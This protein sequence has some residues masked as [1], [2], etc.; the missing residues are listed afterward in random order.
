MPSPSGPS[1]RRSSVGTA[2]RPPNSFRCAGRWCL[3]SPSPHGTAAIWG[4]VSQLVPPTCEPGMVGT[5]ERN[6]DFVEDMEKRRAAREERRRQERA[7][8]GRRPART[9]TPAHAPELWKTDTGSCTRCL[10][11][12]NRRSPIR[13]KPPLVP[14]PSGNGLSAWLS[15]SARS[16]GHPC[17]CRALTRRCPR[18]R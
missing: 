2:R 1:S 14:R 13:R 16:P 11:R 4:P 15:P 17:V 3:R 6:K 7:K 5:M 10:A 8:V 18:S 12:A 9:R